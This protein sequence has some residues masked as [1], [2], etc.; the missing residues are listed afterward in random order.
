MSEAKEQEMM[1]YTSE[2]AKQKISAERQ[3]K[4]VEAVVALRKRIEALDTEL[5]ETAAELEA[6]EALPVDEV[7]L[8]CGRDC[9]GESAPSR[10]LYIDAST[11]DTVNMAY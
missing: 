10:W 1:D 4:K 3:Q 6:L 11:T 7:D 9:W 5:G 2:M 8:R